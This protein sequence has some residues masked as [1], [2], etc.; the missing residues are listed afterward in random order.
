MESVTLTNGRKV[1]LGRRAPHRKF[2]ILD[3]AAYFDPERDATPPPEKVDYFTKAMPALKRI[4]GNDQWG[5]CVI[6]SA[7]HQFGVWSANDNTQGEQPPLQGTDRE[8]VDS[9]HRI[10]GAGD[11][12]C[13]ISDVLDYTIRNGLPLN[14]TTQKIDGYV[15][16]DHTNKLL[17][18]VALDVFG[19]LKLGIYLPQAWTC[20]DCTWGK[21]NSRI[22]GGHDVPAVGYDQTGVQIATWG[23]L[24]TITWEAFLSPRWIEECYVVLAPQWYGSDKLAANG[25]DVTKLRADLAQLGQGGIPDVP[26]P[27]PPPP[28]PPPPIPPGPNVGVP[29]ELAGH[30]DPGKYLIVPLPERIDGQAVGAIPIGKLLQITLLIYA[31]LSSGPITMEKLLALAAQIQ[32]ILAAP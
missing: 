20:T 28:P 27:F 22:V 26:P 2:K 1:K 16:V 25:L 15:S 23:G 30:L 21:T 6:A 32:A 29:L 4:Y 3:L 5:D 17:V 24:V 11:N 13:V 12:G 9:Y 31:T 10:C 7:Y 18:Q 14:G 19:S 8:V